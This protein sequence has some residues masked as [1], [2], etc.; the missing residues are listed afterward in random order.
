MSFGVIIY[1]RTEALPGLLK[2]QANILREAI[3]GAKVENRTSM[4]ALGLL[5]ESDSLLG[6]TN[7][8]ITSGQIVKSRLIGLIAKDRL[9]T[10]P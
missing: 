5:A 8:E 2:L 1:L 6:A 10:L 7:P 4:T 3:A 9:K